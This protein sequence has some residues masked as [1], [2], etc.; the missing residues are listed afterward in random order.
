MVRGVEMDQVV[1]Q[2]WGMR[3]VR[4]SVCRFSFYDAMKDLVK[5]KKTCIGVIIIIHP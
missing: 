3:L 5:L 4:E 2:I 1:R